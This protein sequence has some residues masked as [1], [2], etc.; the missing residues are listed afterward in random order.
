MTIHLPSA[1]EMIRDCKKAVTMT[2]RLHP[3]FVIKSTKIFDGNH[4]FTRQVCVPITFV[5]TIVSD[6]DLR[7][8][9][10]EI[11]EGQT[12]VGHGH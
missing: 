8:V 4:V 6:I 12:Y 1:L 3:C 2:I 7:A 11:A 9:K 10:W 5:R